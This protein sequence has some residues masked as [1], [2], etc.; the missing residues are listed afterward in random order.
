MPEIAF[1]EVGDLVADLRNRRLLGEENP[2]ILLGAGASVESGIEAMD[3]LFDLVR[4]ADFDEFVAYIEPRTPDERYRILAQYLQTRD[5]VQVTPGYRALAQL[6]AEA[7]FDLVLTTNLD[8]LLEDALVG[9]NLRRHDY[10]VLVNGVI[11]PE[12]V[13]PLLGT[14]RPRVK[15]VKLHGD[16]FHRFMAWTPKEMDD[17]LAEIEPRLMP[18][19]EGRDILVLGH[20]LRDAGI[21]ELILRA[22]GAIWYLTP[23]SVPDVLQGNPLVRA[24]VSDDCRFERLFPRLAEELGIGVP[25]AVGEPPPSASTVDDLIAAVVGVVAIGDMP[26]MTGFLLEDPRVIITDGYAGNIASLDFDDVRIVTS[27]GSTLKTEVLRHVPDHPF[28]PLILRAPDSMNAA[29]LPLDPGPP[30]QRA[31]I[32]VAVAAGTR[33]GLS[34]GRVATGTEVALDIAPVGKVEHLVELKVAVAPG[35]SGAPVVDRQMGVKGFIVAGS[36]DPELPKSYMYP[37]GRWREALD[38]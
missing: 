22:G 29:G 34:A 4:C 15:I 2:A 23:R 20:S 10:V 19:L 17:Y 38:L 24:V 13:K 1:Q 3:G 5:P 21:R 9:A 32:Q 11:R 33:T 37:A 31:E 16:L 26:A 35:S 36:T 28:G 27:D 8:P 7:Y 6:C 12:R 25:E 18:A 14:P 30:A